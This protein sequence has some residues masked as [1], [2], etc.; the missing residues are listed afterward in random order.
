MARAEAYPHAK[1]HLNR[2]N[3]LI[4][5][6][7][8]HGQTASTGRRSD[9]IGWTVLQTVA[10]NWINRLRCRLGCGLEWAVGIM[11]WMG[12]HG[13]W[14]TLPWQPILGLKLLL[15]GFVWMIATRQLVM[16]GVWEVGRQNADITDTLH[17]R[18]VAMA[19]IFGF[20]YLGC[21]FC[22]TWRIRLNHS[23]AAAMRPYVKLLWP[24][25]NCAHTPRHW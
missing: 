14:G 21:T 9:S 13:C 3:R 19:T 6:H 24:L 20:L 4:T 5:I 23:C 10:Q 15:T 22:A 25:V 8:R 11:C 1:F 16:N 12:V 2:S 7:Q 17:L 18:D